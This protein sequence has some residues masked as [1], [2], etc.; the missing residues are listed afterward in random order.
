MGEAAGGQV[1]AL[2]PALH[3]MLPVRPKLHLCF[4]PFDSTPFID[5]V[6]AAFSGRLGYR[7]ISGLNN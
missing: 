7:K 2:L 5:H 4:M 3:A 1:Y 6:H